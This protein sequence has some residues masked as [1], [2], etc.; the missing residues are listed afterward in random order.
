MIIRS[1]WA[2]TPA[3]LAAVLLSAMHAN[4]GEAE[5]TAEECTKAVMEAQEMAARLSRKSMSRYVAERHL[6]TANAEAGASEF[7]GC[8]EFAAKAVEEV[9]TRSSRLAPGKVF[10]ATTST[11]DIELRGDDQDD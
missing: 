4:A 8:L 11:G 2:L 9:Q 10:R 1:K 3:M 5:P 7:D 6:H